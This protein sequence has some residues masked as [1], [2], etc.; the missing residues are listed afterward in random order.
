MN[1]NELIKERS[2]KINEMNS[3]LK[4]EN[5]QLRNLNEEEVAKYDTL[6]NEVSELSDKIERAEAQEE[7]NKSIAERSIVDEKNNDETLNEEKRNVYDYINENLRGDVIE[8][9]TIESESIRAHTVGD[10]SANGAIVNDVADLSI[11][12]KKPIWKDMGITHM[13][14]L[15]GSFKLPYIKPLVAGIKGEGVSA[16]DATETLG[17]VDMSLEA[18][19]LSDT[20]SKE[21]IAS[22]KINVVNGLVKNL[23]ESTEKLLTAEIYNEA[24]A[25]ANEVT[26]AT[27]VTLTNLDKLQKQVDAD[28]TF[29]MPRDKFYSAKSVKIDTGSGVFLANKVSNETGKLSDGTD[30]FYSNLFNGTQVLYGDLSYIVVGEWGYDVTFDYVTKAKTREVVVTVSKLA[31]VAN[32]NPESFAKSKIA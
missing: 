25:T 28:G 19:T 31:K 20:F 29:L 8:N 12:G 32:R 26:G 9:F 4:D 2:E 1:L 17:S 15:T 16:D 30:I 3:L 7:L 14:N 27:S 11:I 18:F 24:L 5:E 13:P 10:P 6:K 22:G 21:L 23:I